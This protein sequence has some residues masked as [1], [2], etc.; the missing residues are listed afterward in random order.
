[1]A[2]MN[3]A[4]MRLKRAVEWLKN[5][6]SVKQKDIA[7]KMGMTEVSFSR[8]IASAKEKFI[9]NFNEATGNV[10]NLDYLLSGEGELLA[11]HGASP[12]EEPGSLDQGSLINAALAAK[13]ETIRSKDEMIAILQDQISHLKSEV[14]FLRRSF[15]TSHMQTTFPIGVAEDDEKPSFYT[16]AFPQSPK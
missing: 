16:P 6:R 5:S 2:D 10:F 3:Q 9:I 12:D 13:D 8:G 14:E 15:Q 1:M 7:A 4:Q 11:V